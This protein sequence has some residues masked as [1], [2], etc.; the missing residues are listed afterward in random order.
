MVK[1]TLKDKLT[2]LWRNRVRIGI[3]S[4]QALDKT[5]LKSKE[6]REQGLEMALQI[7]CSLDCLYFDEKKILIPFFPALL[8]SSAFWACKWRSEY[9]FYFTDCEFSQI[10]LEMCPLRMMRWLY[11]VLLFYPIDQIK[12]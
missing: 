9:D 8:W 11:M 7:F 12:R 4:Y 1:R 10:M 5:L 6:K 3:L 2:I